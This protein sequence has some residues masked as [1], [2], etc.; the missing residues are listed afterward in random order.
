MYRCYSPTHPRYAE[1][2]GRGIRV[3][4]EW[5]DFLAFYAA[6][7]PR[8]PGTTLDREDNDGDYTPDNCRWA[9]PDE[10]VRNRKNTRWVEVGGERLCL[11]DQARAHGVNYQTV[12][13][14]IQRGMTP[15]EALTTPVVPRNYR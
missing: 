1:W 2:G 15:I 14:R 8:L 13:M 7:G 4:L 11:K 5:H 3:C 6:M 10:Q 12:F 9:T